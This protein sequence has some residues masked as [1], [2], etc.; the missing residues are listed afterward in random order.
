MRLSKSSNYVGDK[1]DIKVYQ[2]S[3]DTDLASLYL[4]TQ[5]R[6]R[7]GSGVD[8]A[9]GENIDGEFQVFTSSI[10]AGAI[11]VINHTLSATPIGWI[12]VKQNWGG[13]LYTGTNSPT[14]TTITFISTTTTTGY[15]VF[16]LK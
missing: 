2:R 16:L 8:G 7:L 12:V 5:G 15:T 1:T 9:R 3:I 14:N 4:W 13:V 11:N 6:V 10:V